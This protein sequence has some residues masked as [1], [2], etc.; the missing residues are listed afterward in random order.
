MKKLC[1]TLFCFLLFI[2]PTLAK[3]SPY[4]NQ[5]GTLKPSDIFLD[6]NGYPL[7]TYKAFDNFYIPIATLNSAGCPVVYSSKTGK[8]EISTAQDLSSSVTSMPVS[9]AINLNNKSF[10]LYQKEVWLGSLRTHALVSEGR[11]LIP[12]GSLRQ[13]W[14]IDNSTI[15]YIL[16]PKDQLP[17]LASQ[18][19]LENKTEFV[20]TLSIVDFYW[21][22]KLIAKPS[23]HVLTPYETT[24]RSM[25]TLNQNS[26]FYISTLIT[27]ANNDTLNYTNT[28]KYGQENAS[29]FAQ[30]AY[31]KNNKTLYSLGD[32]IDTNTVLWAEETVNKM[33]LHSKTPYLVW[34]NIETQKTYIFEGKTGNWKLIKHFICSTGRSH[35]PT[36]K[37]QFE[38]TR[39]VPYFGVEKGYRCK[40]AFGFIG[41]SY[42]YH[43][44]IF[45]KSGSYL[46]EGK[47]VLGKPASEGCIRF[48]VENSEWF[49]NTMIS[50]SSVW[51]N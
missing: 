51:I 19:R 24:T 33:N 30:Y 34:T 50:G 37:G 29:L 3:S 10:S 38:L 41:T 22:D 27:K 2:F 43:S 35:T 4:T 13:L 40:N 28:N 6:F 17:L 32:P 16:S 21:E 14:D 46:L 47:G 49:Y 31:Q 8:V 45:D 18:D 42:L 11:I 26:P 36:P 25:I 12:I 9:S 44:L 48:S 39:K 1:I 7:Q 15:P 20:T 5:L 23:E